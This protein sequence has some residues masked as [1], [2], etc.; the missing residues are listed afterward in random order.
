MKHKYWSHYDKSMNLIAFTPDTQ[1][2]LFLFETY[3]SLIQK[4]NYRSYTRWGAGSRGTLGVNNNW[5]M[6]S[7]KL[8][9]FEISKFLS[10]S[11]NN[12]TRG[13]CD[14]KSPKGAD[15]KHHFMPRLRNQPELQMQSK[16]LW[17]TAQLEQIS[18]GWQKSQA[19]CLIMPSDW[20]K[21]NTYLCGLIDSSF[22]S[23]QGVWSLL[24]PVLIIAILTD[25]KWDLC[26]FAK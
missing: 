22:A 25:S 9:P 7:W 1:E 14:Y 3:V 6:S 20:I 12:R 17:Q 15:R 19:L 4:V 11:F 18:Q 26:C 23:D 8:D 24:W 16:P 10:H 2:L 21:E 5:N 13:Y